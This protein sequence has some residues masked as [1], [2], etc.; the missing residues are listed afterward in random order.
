M[1]IKTRITAGII[2]CLFLIS[3][4]FVFAQN[5]QMQQQQQE[6]PEVS[7]EELQDFVDAY[8]VVQE[9]QQD[10]N[11]DINELIKDSSL[12]Q[13]EFQQMYQAQTTNNEAAR[14]D[15]SDAKKQTFKKLKSEINGKQQELQKDMVSEIEEYDLSVQRFNSIIAAIQQDSDLYKKFQELQAN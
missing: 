11:Q 5:M 4:G 8:E 2:M 13:Q 12:T 10:L 9:M 3:G 6:V 15:V 7:E 14:S 1:F